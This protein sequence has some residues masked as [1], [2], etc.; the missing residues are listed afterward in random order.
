[1]REKRKGLRYTANFR[2]FFPEFNIHGHTSD[3][4]LDGCFVTIDSSMSVGFITDL[5]LD[6][7]IV[8]VIALKGYVQHL[9]KAESGVGL[10]FVQVRFESDQSDY[11]ILYSRFLQAMSQL[12]EIRKSYLDLV[13]QNRLRL[14]TL[15][16][17]S[18]KA[19]TT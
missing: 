1:M 17:E 10:Q 5:L 14:F 6:L 11:F 4:S 18:G 9:G 2:V 16:S 19:E 8:G 7:P 15:P 3:I 13:Q 12:E